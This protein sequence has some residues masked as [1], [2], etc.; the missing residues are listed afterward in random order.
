MERSSHYGKYRRYTAPALCFAAA[1]LIFAALV[2]TSSG[3]SYT[4]NAA[5]HA[6]LPAS[7]PEAH[8]D[9]GDYL[10]IGSKGLYDVTPLLIRERQY[11]EYA[12][13]GTGSIFSISCSDAQPQPILRIA[14]PESGEAFD[15]KLSKASDAAPS[16]YH[17]PSGVGISFAEG[18]VFYDSLKRILFVTDDSGNST[19]VYKLDY[20]Y[21]NAELTSCTL[22]GR[23]AALRATDNYTGHAV[24]FAVETSS[25]AVVSQEDGVAYI[26][27]IKGG[28]S[29]LSMLSDGSISCAYSSEFTNEDALDF[30]ACFD[31][32]IEYALCLEDA[33]YVVQDTADRVIRRIDALGFETVLAVPPTLPQGVPS[34][35]EHGDMTFIM[36]ESD[37]E[38]RLFLWDRSVYET[39]S[40]SGI[41]YRRGLFK[42]APRA[43]HR[44]NEMLERITDAEERHGVFILC[45]SDADIGLSM[46]A[47]SILTERGIIEESLEI[48]DL[49]LSSYPKDFFR[50]LCEG[51]FDGII[52]EFCGK[53]KSDDDRFHDF[54]GAVTGM[55]GGFKLIMLDVTNP[56]FI[57]ETLCH[58]ICHI[59][60]SRLDNASLKDRSHWSERAWASMNPPGFS[61]YNAYATPDGQPYAA[62]GSMAFTTEAEGISSDGSLND[63]YFI[64]RYSKTFPT[65]D[66]AVAFETLMRASADADCLK[67]PHIQAKLAYYFNAIRYYID[68]HGTWEYPTFWEKKLDAIINR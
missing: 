25:G 39:V 27:G 33:V 4:A 29:A 63:I 53:L 60:D 66:R 26:G 35:C 10:V 57:R 58:E 12:D 16:G 13:V 62:V 19:P 43:L 49:T 38:R 9:S 52:I 2:R 54:P 65:E 5:E 3:S 22:D 8:T 67:S 17:Y 30:R 18:A 47:P 48:T 31:G 56:S 1:I 61:Y 15:K 23:Y 40:I 14:D 55:F 45:G 6:L 68:P 64:D 7:R 44:D 46:Y 51:C 41:H 24:T 36:Y 28:Y 50:E 32:S 34:I 20:R 21:S 59:I 42:D 11:L 37:S